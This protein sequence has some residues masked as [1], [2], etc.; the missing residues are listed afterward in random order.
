M[1][2]GSYWAEAI[3]IRGILYL[4]K[5]NVVFKEYHVIRNS[6]SFATRGMVLN[7]DYIVGLIK[8]KID[9]LLEIIKSMIYSI[10]KH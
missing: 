1:N 7:G 8:F 6:D 3:H 9:K 2:I 4:A 10:C 5:H